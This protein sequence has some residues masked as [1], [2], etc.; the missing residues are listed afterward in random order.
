MAKASLGAQK[1][2]INVQKN[3]RKYQFLN[4]ICFNFHIFFLCPKPLLFSSLTFGS[5]TFARDFFRIIII[6]MSAL[7]VVS[8][9]LYIDLS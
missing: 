2:E 5:G 4:L 1:C 6:A 7:F 3:Y 9:D 8:D